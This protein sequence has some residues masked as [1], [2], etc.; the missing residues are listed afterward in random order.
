MS[1]FFSI[2]HTTR[3]YPRL[4]YEQIKNTVLGKSYQLS[5]V[6]VG[7]D[8]ARAL[9]HAYRKKRYAPNILSFALDKSCGEIFI[10]PTVTKKEARKVHMTTP[11][12]TG[13]LFI[14]GLLHLKGM[15]HGDTM[16]RL[17]TRYCRRYNLV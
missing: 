7:H 3:T 10:T 17:E 13:Y 16:E 1:V 12:Y 9:N 6:F 15:Q 2:G 8:R 14:H 11:D 5:L 4:P